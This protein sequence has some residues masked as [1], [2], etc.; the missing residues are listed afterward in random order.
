MRDLGEGER[1]EPDLERTEIRS[2]RT[3]GFES[4]E[5]DV[6]RPGCPFELPLV[7]MCCPQKGYAHDL[8]C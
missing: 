7:Y 5:D 1:N 3:L 4:Q 8:A 2:E 6:V